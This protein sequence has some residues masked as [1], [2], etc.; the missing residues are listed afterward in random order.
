MRAGIDGTGDEIEE[1][2]VLDLKLVRDL[3]LKWD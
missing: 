3:T 2:L 1:K